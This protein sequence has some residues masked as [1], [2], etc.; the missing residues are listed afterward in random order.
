MKKGKELTALRPEKVFL[1]IG[2]LFGLLFLVVTPPFQVGEEPSHF[3]RAYHVSEFAILAS[4]FHYNKLPPDAIFRIKKDGTFVKLEPEKDENS[5]IRKK[6][7]QAV[8]P[9]VADKIMYFTHCAIDEAKE[10]VFQFQIIDD[11][12]TLKYEALL[13]KI[14][15]DE[16][17]AE[18]RDI[19]TIYKV[20]AFLPA[21]LTDTYLKVTSDIP[22]HPEQKQGLQILFTMFNYPLEPENKSFA[23]FHN[24]ALY[25]PLPYIPQAFGI[26]VGKILNLSPLFL[27]YLGRLANLTVWIFIMYIA[28]RILPSSKWLF[29]LLAFTPMSLSQAA[30]VSAD[31][32]TNAMSFLL[33]AVF[34]KYALN[35]GKR[36][37]KIKIFILLLLTMSV[38][39]SKYVYLP[40][41]FL[42]FLIPVSKF[43]S[44]KLYYVTF[45]SL[46][47]VN[48]IFLGLWSFFTKDIYVSYPF[49]AS[50]KPEQQLLFIVN[51]LIEFFR[52][53]IQTTLL[54]GQEYLKHFIGVLG[55]LDTPLP[56]WLIWSYYFV[57]IT[58]A[59]LDSQNDIQINFKNRLVLFAVFTLIGLLIY[60]AMYLSWTEVGSSIIRGIQGRYFIPIAPLFFLLF[61]NRRIRLNERIL[62]LASAVYMIFVLSCSVYVLLRRY[63]W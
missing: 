27:M 5:G 13:K 58:V 50:V 20:G 1:I 60:T 9:A 24:T 8:P 14:S 30:S 10:Q 34:L 41:L 55:W 62:G 56:D 47:L 36:I 12:K 33:I 4:K 59:L 52:I 19:T 53:I 46:L 16:V 29:P 48:S 7:S 39:L 26:E 18:I 61:Y 2:I 38:T 6:V 23:K 51:N 49:I 43:K 3:F 21:S 42:F 32:F 25:T 63:Y 22:F 44:K 45:I 31:S 17:L 54:S 40:L 28:I 57:L 37:G 15:G 35:D 11:N